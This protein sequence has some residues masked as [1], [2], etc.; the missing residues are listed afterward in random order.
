MKI[1]N[2]IV[3]AII[4]LTFSACSPSGTSNKV[5]A[6]ELT[7]DSLFVG[8]GDASV[9]RHDIFR[10]YYI[11]GLNDYHPTDTLLPHL[12]ELLKPIRFKVVL[13]TWESRSQRVIPQ[14]FSVLFSVG[15]YDPTQRVKVELIGV[16]RNLKAPG[17][18]LTD[19]S[20]QKLPVIVV[21]RGKNEIGRLQGR[22]KQPIELALF[23][24]LNFSK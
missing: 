18:D 20:V 24:M 3:A 4:A 7:G 10:K 16:D 23:Q 6:D 13:G 15:N 21:L 1:R 8:Y 19:L 12:R 5:V 17:I 9:L 2:C 14:L 22:M 11:A